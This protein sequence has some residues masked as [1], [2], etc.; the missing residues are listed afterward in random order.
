MEDMSSIQKMSIYQG[1]RGF[2][3][4][5]R[6]LQL[7]L[8]MD[9]E[10]PEW[11]R[12]YCLYVQRTLDGEEFL[13]AHRFDSVNIYWKNEIKK[14]GEIIKKLKEARCILK[15]YYLKNGRVDVKKANK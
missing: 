3:C 2:F 12:D 6:I 11:S 4:S 1:S 8:D 9:S 10:G 15:Y 14:D 13:P 5:P 7:M